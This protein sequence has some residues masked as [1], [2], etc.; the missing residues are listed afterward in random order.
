MAE[1]K[2]NKSLSRVL[3]RAIG[4]AS[5]R[6]APAVEAE[7]L[8]LALASDETLAASRVLIETGLDRESVAAALDRERAESLSAIGIGP[9]DEE[10]FAAT[11]RQNRPTWGTS[12]KE[13]IHRGRATGGQ[14][15]RRRPAETELLLGILTADLGT[16]PRALALAGVDRGDLL[17]RVRRA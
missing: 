4:E 5:A 15:G 7:H 1:Q 16:V 2:L 6:R 13:A 17:D 9:L 11:P 14:D 3:E 8:L 12:T 10:L